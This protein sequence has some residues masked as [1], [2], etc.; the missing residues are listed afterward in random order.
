MLAK[1]I[2]RDGSQVIVACSACA[3]AQVLCYFASHS[4]KCSE[5]TRKGVHCDGNFSAADYDRLS[6]EQEKLKAARSAA[7]TEASR[8]SAKSSRL[9]AES[10]SLDRR[11][12]ALKRSKGAMMAREARALEELERKEERQ[13]QQ[14]NVALDSVFD[15]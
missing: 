8:L 10:A 5:C 1:R 6:E 9:L 2:L 12:A 11:V 4:S 13:A 3:R 14:A 7:I 15:E